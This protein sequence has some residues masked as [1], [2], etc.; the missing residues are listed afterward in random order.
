MHAA[1][2]RQSFEIYEYLIA[3]DERACRDHVKRLRREQGASVRS[4]CEQIAEAFHSVGDA[5]ACSAI[6]VYREHVASQIG[7]RLLLDLRADLP[8]PA[9]NAPKAIGC[10]PE[11]DPYSLP[12]MMVELAL[13]ELGWQARSLGS[14]LPL[15]MLAPA[16]EDVRP[17]VCWVS[18]SYVDSSERMR[19]QLSFLGE[20]GRTRGVEI[21]CGGQ[22][23][24]N[25]LRHGIEGIT[26]V[27]E[28]REVEDVVSAR[29]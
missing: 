1:I 22:G 25:D 21:L 16:I 27:G 23:L 10:S 24:N 20:L 14:N 19:E 4:V 15:E 3:G 13:Q 17:D 18:V 11:G 2:D 28:L 6:T 29:D 26:F 12:T 9:V 8:V 7:L 5:W